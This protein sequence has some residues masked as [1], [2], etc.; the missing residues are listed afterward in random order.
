MLRAIVSIGVCGFLAVTAPSAVAQ[1]SYADPSDAG[2]RLGAQTIYY[3]HGEAT[4]TEQAQLVIS[5]IGEEAARC[6]PQA[7]DLVTRIDTSAEGPN[8]IALAMTRLNGVAAAL[9]AGGVP[10]DRIRIAAQGDE[11]VIGE[12]L[13]RSPMSEIV[14]LFRQAPNGADEAAAP[15]PGPV[16]LSPR[17]AI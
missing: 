13:A 12:A 11:A 4:P 7:V 8:A 6:R 17:D 2:C 14:V 15:A 9:V 1:T 10:A 5:R 3:P 16:I